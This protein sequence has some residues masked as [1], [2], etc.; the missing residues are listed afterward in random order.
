MA[1]FKRGRTYWFEFL[2]NGQRIQKSTGQRNYKAAVDIESAFRTALA[3]GDVG[4]TERPKVPTLANF[5]QRFMD[6]IT[7]KRGGHPE[8]IDF[9]SRKYD[10][11]LKYKPLAS[12]GLDRID[13]ELIAR[14]IAQMIE[15]EYARSTINHYLRTL[16]RALRLAARRKLIKGAPY[17][18]LL[19]GEHERQFTLDR[20]DE[21]KYLK[22]CPVFL[23]NAAAFMLE[24]GLRRKELV[25][26]RWA[27]VHWQP[28][29]RAR[30]PA[31]AR[32]PI[33]PAGDFEM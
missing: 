26:L 7:V 16:K 30:H 19:D 17:I 20:D 1:V 27:D 4:I 8:T 2:R 13:E 12:A 28:I 18:E 14:F 10:G 23:R 15:E 22:A 25:G 32:H 11:L 24:T 31:G 33:L 3:N 6:E 9:Y 21:P 29:G 5:R